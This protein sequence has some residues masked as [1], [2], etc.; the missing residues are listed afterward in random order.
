[1]FAVGNA[2]FRSGGGDP[3][4][5][6]LS[7]LILGLAATTCAVSARPFASFSERDRAAVF[8]ALLF[9][10]Y[11]GL[12]LVPLPIFFLRIVDPTRASIADALALVT[13][14]P[15]FAPLSIVPA[16]T[17]HHL[18]RIASY[19]LVF[20]LFREMGRRVKNNVWMPALPLIALGA[21]EA[22]FGLVQHYQG[23][24]TVTGTYLSRDF[25]AGLLEMVLPLALMY[26]ITILNRRR[27]WDTFATSSVVNASMFFALGVGMFA[28]IVFSL[29]KGGFLSTLASLFVMG[30]LGWGSKLRGRKRWG[31]AGVLAVLV[32]LVVVSV[33]TYELVQA[34]GGATSDSTA[35]GR[36]PIAQD[37]VRMIAVYP[38]FGTGL[39]TYFPALLRYQTYGLN[40]AWVNAHNDYLELLA[41]L[42]VLGFLIPAVLMSAVFAHAVRRAI[43][44]QSTE[45]RFLG[46]GCTGGLAAML[47]HSFGD[48]NMYVPANAMV[49]AWISGISAGLPG[50]TSDR[51]TVSARATPR[52]VRGSVLV[53][54]CLSSLYAGAWLVFL[55][56]FQA[57]LQAEAAFCRF[58]ICDNNGAMDALV[59]QHGGEVASVPPAEI[60]KLLVR[61][62]AGPYRWED[63]GEA[64]QKSGRIAEARA[65]FARAVTLGPGIPFSSPSCCP[66]SFQPRGK[67]GRLRAHDASSTRQPRVC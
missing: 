66:F 19:A 43:W 35:E 60:A 2:M 39:G 31:A 57:N 51:Q 49:L 9:P 44:E 11:I 30:L 15:R 4:D 58:G 18:S 55:N 41:E 22:V 13:A 26:G 27:E 6:S 65:S 67:R 45:V 62:P 17:W 20:L 10:V 3:A 25:L 7:L 8:C 53:L 33:P 56:S 1:M 12:Q 21:A 42:G 14:A 47:I 48:F 59:Q 16:K 29:S 64:L 46:L 52:F 50:V 40:V 32:L 61:D 24:Q 54:A 23:A 34:I 36:W 63:M 38:L 5:L 37:T 28:T